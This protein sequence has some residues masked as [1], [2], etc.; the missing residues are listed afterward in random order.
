M[1]W[2]TQSTLFPSASQELRTCLDPTGTC[3]RAGQ[4]Q[5]WHF[6]C[7][8][9]C[10]DLLVLSETH[11]GSSPHYS[12]GI[13]GQG[14]EPS[15][16]SVDVCLSLQ[17]LS[18]PGWA[19][20]NE[21]LIEKKAV[22][23]RRQR[24]AV[25]TERQRSNTRLYS[26]VIRAVTDLIQDLWN[27]SH[28]SNRT[29]FVGPNRVKGKDVASWTWMW[30]VGTDSERLGNPACYYKYMVVS[31]KLGSGQMNSLWRGPVDASYKL[32]SANRLYPDNL[33]RHLPGWCF[34]SWIHLL[35]SN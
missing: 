1:I 27:I 9:G 30:V 2:F 12:L 28:F 19:C 33:C 20:K 25:H 26:Q 14:I 21:W 23:Q 15:Q 4:G 16:C 10:S 29:I 35:W 17:G 18:V 3:S 8:F 5:W 32:V 22:I 7:L 11:C 34:K 6:P 24:W 13:Q 31:L